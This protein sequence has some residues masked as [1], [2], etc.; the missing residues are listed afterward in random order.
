[1]PSATSE[2]WCAGEIA[3]ALRS[4]A[5]RRRRSNPGDGLNNI[6]DSAADLLAGP[7]LSVDLERNCASLGRT[8]VRVT[9]NQAVLLSVLAAADRHTVSHEKLQSALW[10]LSRFGMAC[11]RRSVVNLVA[12][13]N[14]RLRATPY[15]I[16]NIRGRGYQL[17]RV[18]R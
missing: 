13:L 16:V 1:M 5:H 2:T 15:L 11:P 8:A 12:A 17:A 10:G 14:R 3:A 6:F 7:G 9:P 4:F 18:K